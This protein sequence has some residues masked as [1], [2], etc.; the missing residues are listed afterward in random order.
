MM[1][2]LQTK[3][4]SLCGVTRVIS[5]IKY[6]P[7]CSY[8]SNTDIKDQ[9]ISSKLFIIQKRKKSIYQVIDKQHAYHYHPSN[10]PLRDET[11]GQLLEE[12]AKKWSNHECIVSHHQNIRLTFS[13]VLLRV[14]KLAAGM[15]KLGFQKGDRIGIFGPNDIEWFITFLC[16]TRLGLITVAINSAYQRDELIYCLQKV[17]AK[18]IVLPA[19]FKTQNYVNMALSAKEFC[20]D[21]E[22]IIVWSKDH[23][24]GTR[25]FVD[26]ESLASKIEVEAVSAEQGNVSSYDACNIQ[27]TSGTTGKPK[28]TL[29]SHRSFVNNSEQAVNRRE[30]QLGHKSCLNVPLFHAFG[31]IFGQ[32]SG[33][34][35]GC[36]TILESRSFDPVKSLQVMVEEK[37][38]VT[39]GTPT[40]WINLID[41]QQLLRLP[42]QARMGVIGGAS[43]PCEL[44]K[45]IKDVLGIDDMKIIYGL[46]ELTGVTFQ[47]LPGED[48]TLTQNTVGYASDNIEVMVVNE[49]GDPVPFG[50]PG[51]LW[52]RGYSSMICY[53]NDP[54]NTKKTLTEDGWLKTGDQFILQ[55]NGYGQIVGRIKDIII[56]GGEN[57]FPREIEDFLITHP[58]IAEAHCVGAYDEIF[59]EEICACIRLFKGTSLS[60]EELKAYCKGKIAHFKIPRYV[61]FVEKYPKTIS[62][63][64]QK[65]KL[66]EELES[67][68]VIPTTPK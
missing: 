45:R 17:G 59:G 67:K 57:I 37:C 43:I 27:F 2:R 1:F 39:Y 21:L 44:H 60:K 34:L 36:T 5:N 31:L 55:S 66:K 53:Y 48:K 40:M 52:V 61:V 56:R 8:Y 16:A 30:L 15:K 46:T 54:E 14:D 3:C 29:L 4:F 24:T 23:V 47:S 9:S 10:K 28:A 41:T 13:D 6:F 19:K 35:S 42:V 7:R 38:N 68:G 20:P 64:I 25:R 26:V 12:A 58:S 51:E 65:A 50:S 22:H 62:G 11:I 32:I 33:I 63:K 49:K 18:G